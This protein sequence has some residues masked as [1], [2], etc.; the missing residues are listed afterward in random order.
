MEATII[1]TASKR[2]G[3][4]GQVQ[5]SEVMTQ[6][7]GERPRMNPKQATNEARALG[8]RTG[9]L[10][11]CKRPPGLGELVAA[12]AWRGRGDLG[13]HCV[14]MKQGSGITDTSTRHGNNRP[15]TEP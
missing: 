10:I 13:S 8:I 14:E 11:L 7:R 5:T 15:E 9:L 12:E 3:G 4:D 1:E 2:R 6:N